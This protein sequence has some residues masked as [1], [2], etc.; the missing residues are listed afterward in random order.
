MYCTHYAGFCKSVR[1]NPV[2]LTGRRRK[3]DGPVQEKLPVRLFSAHLILFHK[4]HRIHRFSVFED[5]KVQVGS[6]YTVI[7][8]RFAEIPDLFPR[9]D[10]IAC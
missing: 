1:R 3:T 10:I 2:A 8:G 6:F 9:I 5:L 7:F 4:I